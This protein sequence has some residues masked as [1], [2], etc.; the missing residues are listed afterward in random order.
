MVLVYISITLTVAY[1]VGSIPTALIVSKKI[2][3]TDIRT[4]GDGN[5][6]AHN[7]FH[8][9][10]PKFGVMVAAIDIIKGVIPV[11]LA[12]ILGLGLGWQILVG[13]FAVLGHDFPVWAS[14]KGGQGTATSF[15]TMLALFPLPALIG[16]GIYGLFY[17]I[18]RNSNVSCGIC[19]ASI[20]LYLGIT[21]QW[22][23][24]VYAVSA[25]LFIPIKLYI[26]SPRRRVIADMRK[27][28]IHT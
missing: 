18:I 8:T 5:M 10:G 15:G 28:G 20:A 27:N 7:T 4:I 22:L 2:K 24:F 25:F 9:I 17:L 14:F 26:D 19:G 11:V 16:L 21:Q 6:G 13:I 1:S 3:H 23:L 12:S